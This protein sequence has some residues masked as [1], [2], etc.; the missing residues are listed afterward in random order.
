MKLLILLL[1]ISGFT[2]LQEEHPPLQEALNRKAYSDYREEGKYHNRIEILRKA[3]EK[4]MKVL[5]S[6]VNQ[7]QEDSVRRLLA[8]CRTIISEAEEQTSQEKNEKELR[9]KEVKK[10]EII[11]RKLSDETEDLKLEFPLEA[12]APFEAVRDQAEKFRD[13]LL[14]NLF[15]EALG[16]PPPTG[17]AQL[18]PN[19]AA[20]TISPPTARSQGLW[21]IDKFTEEE[22]TR[23]QYAQKLKDRTE[24]FL[25][26]AQ[27]RLDEIDRRIQGIEWEEE[28]P[29]PL[30]FHLYE[31][32]LHA[33]ARA[34]NGVM[35]NIDDKAESRRASDDEIREALKMLLEKIEEFA[36]RLEKLEDLV[37]KERDPALLEKYREA[38]KKTEQ[39]YR[40]AKFGLGSVPQG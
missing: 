5:Q 11:L 15:G 10:M 35:I 12:R 4:K 30:E 33:Y 19:P 1:C 31:D 34:V 29:N 7:H 40:G 28:E 14:R 16:T 18:V 36:P 39:A 9:H 22:F 6:L 8:Q 25:E 37:R 27:S 20:R 23:I 3:L 32:L 13:R 38:L 24:V 2:Y 21:D 26:I 17:S